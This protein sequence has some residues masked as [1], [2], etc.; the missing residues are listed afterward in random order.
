MLN[1][2][3]INPDHKTSVTYIE[4]TNLNH[5]KELQKYFISNLQIQN[6]HKEI[7]N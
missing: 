5:W 6:G 1:D 4:M 3:I 7:Q 2:Q